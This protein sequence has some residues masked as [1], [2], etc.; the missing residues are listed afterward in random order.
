MMRSRYLRAGTLALGFVSLP[1]CH[2]LIEPLGSSPDSDIYLAGFEQGSGAPIAMYW[3]NGAAFPLTNDTQSAI[4]DGIA[5]S[6]SDVYVVGQQRGPT[7]HLLAMLWKN[8]VATAL[9]DGT[10]DGYANGVFVSGADIYVCGDEIGEDASGNPSFAAEYWKNGVPT[11]LS[12]SSE[13]E[14]AN[15]IFVSGSDVYVAGVQNET[16]QTPSGSSTYQ[17]ATYWKDGAASYLTNG[18]ASAVAF[19]IFVSGNDV[20]VSGYNCLLDASGCERAAYWKN[21]ALIQLPTANISTAAGIAAANGN[22]YVAD[23]ETF[24]PYEVNEAVLWVNQSEDILGQ[25]SANAVAVSGQDV[26]VAGAG[27]DGNAGY[28]K[29]GAFQ[30]AESDPNTES[31]AF[32]IAIVPH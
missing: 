4:A 32:A 16:T 30:E 25:G 14:G 11:V 8:G 26:Y 20:F 28:F 15:A 19:S 29:N 2:S 27:S 5:V 31:S 23:N 24:P 7:G 6:G 9:T 3:K 10:K 13:G 17:V 18:T 21:G 1:G 12:N 22:V